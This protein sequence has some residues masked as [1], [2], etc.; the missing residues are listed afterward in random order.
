MGRCAA[1]QG[2]TRART[3]CSLRS[4]SSKRFRLWNASRGRRLAFVY[5]LAGLFLGRH[6]VDEGRR[7]DGTS[8]G[9]RPPRASWNSR[10]GADWDLCARTAERG[11]R[12]ESRLHSAGALTGRGRTGRGGARRAPAGRGFPFGLGAE[13]CRRISRVS[14]TPAPCRSEP[15]EKSPG[16]A[17]CSKPAGPAPFAG[18]RPP[19]GWCGSIGLWSRSVTPWPGYRLRP[20]QQEAQAP[21]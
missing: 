16:R 9:T 1:P 20:L 3:G 14:W 4:P 2:P 19:P 11:S 12:R 18:L 15:L 5:S 8:S 7:R 21:V 13:L 17:E 6:L 10:S